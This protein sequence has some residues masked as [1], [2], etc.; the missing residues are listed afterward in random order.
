MTNLIIPLTSYPKR[1][2][3]VKTVLESLLGQVTNFEYKIVLSLCSQE[4]PKYELDLPLD[5][6]N[7]LSNNTNKIE[8]I[9]VSKNLKSH[10]K[11]IP[12]L[13]RYPNIPILICDDDICRTSDWAQTFYNDHKLYPHD[14]IVGTFMYSIQS[15]LRFKRLIDDNGE[16]CLAFNHIPSIVYDFCRP[17]NGCGGLLYPPGTFTDHRFFN[18]DL[19]MEL[20]ET[21]DESWQYLF[22]ILENKTFRQL[23]IVF[24]HSIGVIPESQKT[25]LYR[26]NNYDKIFSELY[27]RFPEFKTKLLERQHNKIIVSFTTYKDRLLDPNKCID[28]MIKSILSQTHKIYKFICVIL[29]EDVQYITRYMKDCIDL[30]QLEL[31][32][33]KDIDLK[34]HKKYLYTMYKYQ[35]YPII[36]VDDDIQYSKTLVQTLV[37]SYI[38]Y[39]NCISAVRTHAMTYDHNGKLNKYRNFIYEQ[40]I[41]VDYPDDNLFF[42]SGAGT[43][44]PPNCLNILKNFDINLVLNS[45]V[46]Y[47]DDV[48][49]NY[50][51][52]K[53]NVK[54][55]QTSKSFK[56]NQELYNLPSSKINPLYKQNI[57]N[58]NNDVCMKLLFN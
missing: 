7:L 44:F 57:N 31:L 38:K 14:I 32:V 54:V 12:A 33:V 3:Y 27:N 53:N 24:D 49:L 50:L 20:C 17:A 39:P 15:D 21:S 40:Q 42:T 56:V 13:K 35:N 22:N 16:H 18:E 52:K 19:M 58:G 10:K 29:E 9:W 37:D 48:Y 6:Q 5:L 28:Y 8:V 25:G 41:I 46:L 4:F 47:C 30:N 45:S 26:I 2:Q 51:A 43:L 1:I 55:V 11:L 34:S 36:L 23:S